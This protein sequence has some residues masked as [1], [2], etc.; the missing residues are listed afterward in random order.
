M[1]HEKPF[2]FQTTHLKIMCKQHN[3]QALLFCTPTR[4]LLFASSVLIQ[5]DNSHIKWAEVWRSSHEGLA[6]VIGWLVDMLLHMHSGPMLVTYSDFAYWSWLLKK[7]RH[8]K[9]RPCVNV[10]RSL[11]C[12]SLHSPAVVDSLAAV[13]SRGSCVHFGI[14]MSATLPNSCPQFV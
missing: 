10:K 2:F 4:P 11:L 9:G 1:N 13:V 3:L 12:T 14:S 8:L 7:W 5:L 6:A